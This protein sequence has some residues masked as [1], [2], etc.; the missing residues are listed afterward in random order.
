VLGEVPKSD[1]LDTARNDELSTGRAL[2]PR[3]S[4]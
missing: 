4:Y 1:A 2:H 3:L